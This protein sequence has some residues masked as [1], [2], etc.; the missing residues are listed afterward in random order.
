MG[1]K[2]WVAL[3][4]FI[5][6]WAASLAVAADLSL[7]PSVTQK[8][9][10]NSN[11]NYDFSKPIRDYIFTLTPAA[12]FNYTTEITQLQ[13]HLGLSGQHYLNNSNLDH[14]DQNFQINGWRQAAPRVKLTLNSSYISDS[15]LAE[16]IL[17]SGL[18][19]SRTPRQSFSAGP[20]ITYN[21]TERVLAT[22]SYNFNRVLYQSPQYIDYTSHQAG[23]NFTYLLTNE[24][25]SL[26]SN[27]IVRETIYSG[28]NNFKSLGIYLGVTHKF[29]ERW[30]VSL[31]SGA[32]IS[33]FSFNTQVVDSSQFPFFITVKTQRVKDSNATPFFNVSS[34]YRWTNLTMGASYS[35]NQSPSAYGA[36]YEVDQLNLFLNYKFTERLS[37]GLSGSY[38]LSNQ[39]SQTIASTYNYYS[40]TPNLAYQ[41]TEKLSVSPGYSYSGREN[42]T[43]VTGGGGSAHV[44]QAWI[45]FSYTYPLHYQK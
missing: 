32:N 3:A 45:Q 19:M 26:I 29:S 38:S 13:G 14:I 37:G 4:I 5:S 44:H 23:L 28:G 6:M 20:G 1:M 27:N 30:D 41:I 9:E 10:F 15:S 21:L 12:D 7:V 2:A 8:S 22:A 43:G 39:S 40:I 24:T 36:V 33:F 25:T 11:L 31:M 42:L 35:R 16:E 18:V 34:N 17:A